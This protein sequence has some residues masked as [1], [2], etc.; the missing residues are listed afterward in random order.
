MPIWKVLF[1]GFLTC[2]C[3]V[4]TMA[5][6]AVPISQEGAQRWIW[7]AGLLLGTIGAGTLLTLFL[8]HAGGSLE[9]KSRWA[10][11]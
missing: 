4:L 5:T 9:F 3:L 11:I 10:R 2:L 1:I 6:I 8:R 7:L